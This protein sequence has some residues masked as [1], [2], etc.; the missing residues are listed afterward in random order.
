MKNIITIG[1][2]I[3][4]LFANA[5]DCSDYD[6][7]KVIAGKFNKQ[8]GTE[9]RIDSG[10]VQVTKMQNPYWSSGSGYYR[11]IY[12]IYVDYPAQRYEVMATCTDTAGLEIH[13]PAE[14]MINTT[15]KRKVYLD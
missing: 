2:F 4:L 3:S 13:G 1:L 6:I 7:R 5:N 12:T 15:G 9:Y 11:Y 8:F 10:D 14:A